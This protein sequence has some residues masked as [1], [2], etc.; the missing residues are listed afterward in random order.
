V[1]ECQQ[2]VD[3]Q[4][5]DGG[6]KHPGHIPSD[7][8]DYEAK[9]GRCYGGD[10][11]DNRV[12]RVRLIRSHV[13]VADKEGLAQGDEG[14]D[15]HIIGHTDH[16]HHP[17]VQLKGH[18]VAELGNLPTRIIISLKNPFRTLVHPT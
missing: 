1:G 2:E 7:L 16:R 18:D 6:T 12:D 3:Q 13:E 8:I 15:G 10:Q 9:Q 11:V 14:K 17:K 4:R 5:G